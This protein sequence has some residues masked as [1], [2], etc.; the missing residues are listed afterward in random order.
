[1]KKITFLLLFAI[2]STLAFA[3]GG[4]LTETY[5][6]IVQT[7]AAGVNTKWNGDYFE[8]TVYN[9]RR[10]A[11]DLLK[12]TGTPG[13]W[14]SSPA[15]VRSS[16]PIEGGI[17]AVS[18]PWSQFGNESTRML[19]MV[20]IV[21]GIRVDSIFQQGVA[22]AIGTQ[23]TF[24]KTDIN[25]KKN[26]TLYLENL[27]YTTATP[28]VLG[29]RFVLGNITWTPYLRY[30]TK[31]VTVDPGTQYTNSGLINNLDVDM[32]APVYT[33]S[34]P[35]IATVDP[36]TG[37]VTAIA[38]GTTTITATSGNVST[39]YLLT[40]NP[41]KLVPSFSYATGKIYKLA[42]NGTFTNPLTNNSDGTVTYTSSNE[43]F[44]TVNAGTGLITLI[45]E[46][47]CTITASVPETDN[48]Q[49]A[50]ASYTLVI[51]P[52]NWKMETFDNE[53]TTAYYLTAPQTVAGSQASW[54]CFLGGIQKGGSAF[55]GVTNGAAYVKAKY[56]DAVDYGYVSSN[57]I[58]GGIDSL[59]FAWNSNGAEATT[60]WDIRILINDNEVYQFTQPGNEAILEV[61]DTIKVGGLNIEGN[62]TI[63][64]E[65]RSTISVAYTTAIGGNKGRFAIDELQWIGYV[66]TTTGFNQVHNKKIAVYPTNIS[67]FIN[68][69]T[70]EKEFRVSIYNQVG[71]LMIEKQN[72]HSIPVSHLA[73]GLYIVN[74][75]TADGE[76][77]MNKVFKR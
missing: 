28:S 56:Q 46:G 57:A 49:A 47:T 58:A 30:T 71:S 52:G 5:S 2:A 26:A 37:E 51:K 38:E 39:T 53:I 32:D 20:I 63:K 45:A 12:D 61:P 48:Y 31:T 22:N 16:N 11:T 3:T 35:A 15:Y 77:S 42:T 40:V 14:F 72:A 65:N 50:N 19:K 7:S 13:G 24:S 27:S 75:Q 23:R 67:D 36:A 34:V 29:G 55:A 6:N 76:N 66:D 17:K 70:T 8:W 21:D 9:I 62:F 74:V 64:F 60:N 18:F 41:D 59:S 54:T 4:T 10:A 69:Q 1:M 68:I 25:C 73:A 44:A 33:S 43:A